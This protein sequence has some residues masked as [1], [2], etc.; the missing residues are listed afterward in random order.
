MHLS[1]AKSLERKTERKYFFRFFNFNE[2]FI[3]NLFQYSPINK[4]EIRILNETS[5]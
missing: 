3:F 5:I 2:F 4:Q 1:S